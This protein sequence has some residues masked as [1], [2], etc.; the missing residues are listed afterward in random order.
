[1]RTVR[2]SS[3]WTYALP[4]RAREAS[5]AKT[6]SKGRFVSPGRVSSF[7]THVQSACRGR[8]IEELAEFDPRSRHCPEEVSSRMP[9]EDEGFAQ[10]RNALPGCPRQRQPMAPSPP[11]PLS[12]AV[13]A[14]RLRQPLPSP[15]SCSRRFGVLVDVAFSHTL[16]RSPLRS[17]SSSYE[18]E[19]ETRQRGAGSGLGNR[20]VLAPCLPQAG[21]PDEWK[22]LP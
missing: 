2:A 9:C 3:A 18:R 5:F 13:S 7:A 22:A 21:S 19:H 12:A 1:M 6:C 4:R 11:L 20:G 16:E 10:T 14:S 17:S 8:P 15:S